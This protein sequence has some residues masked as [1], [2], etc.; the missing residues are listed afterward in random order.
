MRNAKR[1]NSLLKIDPKLSS[2]ADQWALHLV[3]EPKPYHRSQ[4]SL[5]DFIKTNSYRFLSENL[6]R[7]PQGNQP[8]HVLQRWLQSPVHR[9]NLLQPKIRFMGISTQKAT[10]GEW[11]VVWNGGA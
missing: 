6:H 8:S 5:I 2:L 1:T 9:K 3:R 4:S 10:S 7:S 11:T